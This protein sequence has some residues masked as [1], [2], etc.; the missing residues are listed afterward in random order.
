MTKIKSCHNCEYKKGDTCILSGYHYKAERQING[1][2]N[3]DFGGWKQKN[4][5]IRKIFAYVNKVS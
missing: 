4:T 3:K 1:I 2:C 5:L